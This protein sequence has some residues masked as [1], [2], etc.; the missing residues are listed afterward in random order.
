MK[1]S[2]LKLKYCFQWLCCHIDRLFEHEFLVLRSKI[3]CYSSEKTMIQRL[4][5]QMVK[6]ETYSFVDM[7]DN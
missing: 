4:K 6:L 1:E 5:E 7:F 3:E 2:V